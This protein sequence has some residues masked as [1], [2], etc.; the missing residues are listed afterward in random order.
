MITKLNDNLCAPKNQIARSLPGK[1]TP[2]IIYKNNNWIDDR[3]RKTSLIEKQVV[4][5]LFRLFKIFF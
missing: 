5:Y 3:P 1:L 2:S 4:S